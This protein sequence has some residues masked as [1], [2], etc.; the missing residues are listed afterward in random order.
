MAGFLALSVDA[1]A[2]AVVGAC[3]YDIIPGMRCSGAYV[4]EI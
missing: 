2:V 4:E 3:A 1:V